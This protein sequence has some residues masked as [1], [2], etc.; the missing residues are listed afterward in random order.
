MKKKTIWKQPFDELPLKR[1]DDQRGMLFEIL[2]FKDFSIPANGQLY[3]FSIESKQRRGDHFHLKKHEWFTCVH[4]EAIVLLTS[5]NG[6][7]RHFKLDAQ[8]P[9]V[10]YAAP[11]TTHALINDKPET[12]VIVSYGSTQHD[13][14]DED[15]FKKNAYENFKL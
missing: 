7:N 14:D 10:I 8:K 2:R 9:S 4:G 5:K 11:G 12:A 3:T 13:P 6:I 15:T 1:Y